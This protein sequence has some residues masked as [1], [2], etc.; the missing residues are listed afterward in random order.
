MKVLFVPHEESMVNVLG[1]ALGYYV[2]GSLGGS[3]TIGVS[4]IK[5]GEMT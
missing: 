3:V 5:F 4:G 2:K 1:I